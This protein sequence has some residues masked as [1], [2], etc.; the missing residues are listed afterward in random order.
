[1]HGKV[2]SE[3]PRN[4]FTCAQ[5]VIT[6]ALAT[7]NGRRQSSGELDLIVRKT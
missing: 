1:M 2:I 6:I 7:W 4:R 5:G 3:I